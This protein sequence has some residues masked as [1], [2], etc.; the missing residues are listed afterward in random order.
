MIDGAFVKASY[1][2]GLIYTFLNSTLWFLGIHGANI[3]QPLMLHLNEISAAN[4]GF[5]NESFLGAFVFIG[6]SGATFS[7]ILAITLFSKNKTLRLLSYDSVPIALMNI[8]ELLV[9]GLPIIL[10]PR[11]FIPFLVVPLVNVL[12]SFFAIY[13][14]WVSL[15][16][17][18][19]PFN[20]LVGLNA[21]LAMHHDINAVFLQLC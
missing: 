4:G 10:N 21:Y 19:V 11:M 3:L 8:N 7:L 12:T 1:P 18:Q 5:V 15:P 14:G 13:F 2:G 16:D 20:A 6:G 9:F 17:A